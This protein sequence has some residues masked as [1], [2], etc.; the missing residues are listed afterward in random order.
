[1]KTGKPEPIG[2]YNNDVI[3]SG[4]CDESLNAWIEALSTVCEIKDNKPESFSAFHARK[5]PWSN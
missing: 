2:I 3:K 1:M 4:N 5:F